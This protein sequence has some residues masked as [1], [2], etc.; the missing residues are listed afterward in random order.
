MRLIA[1]IVSG[2]NLILILVFSIRAKPKMVP[3]KAAK[4]EKNIIKENYFKVVKKL[5]K[6][7]NYLL[8]M[9]VVC[10]TSGPIIAF[11]SSL[12]KTLIGLGYSE[13][14][15]IITVAAISL[16]VYGLI[17]NQLYVIWLKK[18]NKFRFISIIS[19]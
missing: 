14:T 6:N 15:H 11:Q 13:P 12:D 16:L 4:A 10:L 19:N 1:I 3:S 2:P 17:G 18:T 8:L 5:F 7:K 9:V